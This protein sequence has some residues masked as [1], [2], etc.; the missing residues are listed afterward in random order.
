MRFV[1]SDILFSDDSSKKYWKRWTANCAIGELVGIGIAG[2]IAYTLNT[3]L[4]EPENIQSRIVILSAM[5]FAGSIEGLVLGVF[6][7]RILKEK[8]SKIPK[9]EWIG[10]TIVV[11]M[12]GWFLG[13]LPSLFLLPQDIIFSEESQSANMT[14]TFLFIALSIGLGLALGALFGLFQWFS[15]RKYA[16]SAGLWILANSIGWGIGIGWIFLFASLPNEHTS[17]PIIIIG[18]MVGG[19]LAGLSVGAVTG[20]FLLKIKSKE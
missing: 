17:L 14:S 12:F 2:I 9:A 20:I 8:Y 4:G 6:Q 10:Y 11:A 15:F 18:G 16:H 1:R 5:M 3:I 13:M 7:W 19:L